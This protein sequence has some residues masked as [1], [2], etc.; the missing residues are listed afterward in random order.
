MIEEMSPY[1]SDRLQDND[2]GVKMAAIQSIYEIT[3]IN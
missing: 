3:R 1:L 2:I